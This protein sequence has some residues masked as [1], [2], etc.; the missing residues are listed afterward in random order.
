MILL[1][2]LLSLGRFL[3]AKNS[4][5]MLQN[6]F[7]FMLKASLLRYLKFDPDVLVM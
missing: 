6:A 2:P 5:T 4:L 1:G 3:T 7:F